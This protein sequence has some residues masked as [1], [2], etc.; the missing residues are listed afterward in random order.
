MAI[1]TRRVL[2]RC[3]DESHTYASD[4]I[5]RG[6]VSKLKSTGATDYVAREW[7]IVLLN[8][9]SH[10]GKLQHEPNLGGPSRPDVVFESDAVKFCAD[11]TAISDRGF[12]EQNPARTLEDQLRKRYARSETTTGGLALNI[13]SLGFPAYKGMKQPRILPPEDEF[14]DLI[15]NGDFGSFLDYV[16]LNPLE[17]KTHTIS[18]L[19]LRSLVRITYMPGRRGVWCDSHPIPQTTEIEKNPLFTALR[20]KVDQLTHSGYAGPCGMVICDGGAEV[21]RENFSGMT[22]SASEVIFAFFKK[23]SSINFVVTLSLR[24]G[25]DGTLKQRVEYRIHVRSVETW[26]S[27]LNL[28][29]AKIVEALPQVVQTPQNALNEMRFW[30]GRARYRTHLGGM[31]VTYHGHMAKEIRMSTRALLELLAGRISQETFNQRFSSE[32]GR[33]IFEQQLKAGCLLESA[34]VERRSNEDFDEIVLKFGGPDPAASEFAVRD[35]K[36]EAG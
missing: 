10:F 21:L 19:H 16:K 31:S 13:S 5:R 3:I 35:K 17:K 12:D 25:Y 11:I 34:S 2:Q 28:L 22:Y 14:D 1:F 27:E 33:N 20:D 6:W 7:E 32:R 30:E 24:N 4:T 26:H 15:F 29:F 18:L 8:T 9:L 36:T 23:H